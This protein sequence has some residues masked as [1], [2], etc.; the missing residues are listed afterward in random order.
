[1][2]SDSQKLTQKPSSSSRSDPSPPVEHDGNGPLPKDFHLFFLFFFS[3]FL[4]SDIIPGLSTMLALFHSQLSYSFLLCTFLIFSA[5]IHTR[6]EPHLPTKPPKQVETRDDRDRSEHTQHSI[7]K[8]VMFMQGVFHGTVITQRAWQACT[9]SSTTFLNL[10][11]PSTSSISQSQRDR[12]AVS[13]D[14]G[15]TGAEVGAM[16]PFRC[17]S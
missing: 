4:I 17:F 10:Y 13:A 9:I 2:N 7:G 11:S 6:D 3:R 8:Y 1:M 16:S 15:V 12:D 14:S 5:C